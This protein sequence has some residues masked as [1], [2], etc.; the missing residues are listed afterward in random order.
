MIVK[1]VNVRIF[2][3]SETFIFEHRQLV[4]L[5]FFLEPDKYY[6]ISKLIFPLPS[7]QIF[8]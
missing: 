2:H 7:I 4:E 1:K 6:F 5:S 3:Y 8:D